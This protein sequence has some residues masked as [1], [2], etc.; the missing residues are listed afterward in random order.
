MNRIIQK[1][2]VADWARRW[3]SGLTRFLRRK[4]PN[5][6][7]AEDLAQ[8]VYVRLLRM[9]SLEQINEPQAYVY[10]IASNVASE[11]RLRAS[12]SKPHS[13]DEL[14]TLVASASPET[15][16]DE[17]ATEAAI[18]GALARMSPM[19]RAV[20]YL[21]VQQGM[22]HDEIAAHLSISPRMV[23]RFLGQ[24]YLQLRESVLTDSQ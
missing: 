24:G 4:V 6:I 17:Q 11:W 8:E 22:S 9:E 23:R 16:L 21:K 20:T 14:E 10:R 3:N 7:D 19:V 2:R 18:D 15:E 5:Q 13:S 1:Q 12:Q